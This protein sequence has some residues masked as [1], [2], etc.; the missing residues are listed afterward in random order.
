M[1]ILLTGY[2]GLLGRHIARSLKASGHTVRVTLHQ[3]TVA[4][5]DFRHEADEVLWGSLED[6]LVQRAALDGVDAVVHSAW[7]FSAQG[8]DRP[9]VNEVVTESLFRAAVKAG[10]Q[11]FAFISSVAVYGMSSATDDVRTESSPVV[12][13]VGGFIYPAEK[14]NTEQAFGAIPRG[15]MRLAIFRPGP[16]FDDEKSPVKK[17]LRLGGRNFG[18]G[19]GTGANPMPYIHAADVADAV[20]RWIGSGKDGLV[21]NLTPT[22]CYDHRTWFRAW[23]RQQGLDISPLFVRAWVMRFA[24]FAGTTVKRMMG[25]QGKVDV[26]Y[27]LAAASRALR[28]SNAAARQALGWTPVHTDRYRG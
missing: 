18:L 25:K 10:V 24:A 21:L 22:D 4:R 28:Y 8:A 20:A 27:A 23:G 26:S 5:L 1:K 19:F 13:P 14:V 6:P 12:D 9:T 3:R 16:I 7:K 17:V 11:E 2:A 15:A